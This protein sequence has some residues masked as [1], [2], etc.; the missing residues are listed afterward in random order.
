MDLEIAEL[1]DKVR[2]ERKVY[3]DL[4]ESL[5]LGKSKPTSTG[6]DDN[7]ADDSKGAED[8]DEVTYAESKLRVRSLAYI[9]F[10]SYL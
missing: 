1:V 2:L 3:E 10:F 5:C 7:D 8:T 4:Y 6:D 9:S